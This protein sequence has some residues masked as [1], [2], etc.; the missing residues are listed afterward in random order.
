MVIDQPSCE[1]HKCVSRKAS[2]TW[3]VAGQDKTR[4]ERRDVR[5]CEGVCLNVRALTKQR[6]RSASA[7]HPL[8]PGVTLY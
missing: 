5:V 3:D 6:D 4:Q 2:K 1:E 8:P 7:T